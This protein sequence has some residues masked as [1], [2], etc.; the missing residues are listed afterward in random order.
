MISGFEDNFEDDMKDV[1]LDIENSKIL[2]RIPQMLTPYG[3]P[4]EGR[5]YGGY[6]HQNGG[7]PHQNGGTCQ[8]DYD[9]AGSQKC[10]HVQVAKHR[11]KL[12]CR[13]PRMNYF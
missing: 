3:Y 5:H 4:Q 1:P 11:F 8:R 6:P 9:C 12:G 10:C 2:D 7:Y 13:Y